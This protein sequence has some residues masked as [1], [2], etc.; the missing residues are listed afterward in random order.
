MSLRT[1]GF[2]IGVFYRNENK[3]SLLDEQAGLKGRF[4]GNGTAGVESLFAK[5]KV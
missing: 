2:P 3:P 1:D 4:D 5:F